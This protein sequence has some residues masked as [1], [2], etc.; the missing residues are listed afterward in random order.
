GQVLA[1]D[2]QDGQMITTVQGNTLMVSKNGNAVSLTDPRGRTVQVIVPD[3][4]T[5]N[6]VVH[7]VDGVLLP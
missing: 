7:A 2:L 1:A 6:G 3:V 4:R 5:L